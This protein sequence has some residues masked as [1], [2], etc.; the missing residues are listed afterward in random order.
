MRL[1]RLFI[2]VIL[3]LSFSSTVAAETNR[4][5]LD[6]LL[7]LQLV[8]KVDTNMV[9]LLL[10]IG[11]QYE[12]INLDSADMWYIKALDEVESINKKTRTY[13]YLKAKGIDFRAYVYK[14]KH[15]Y[16]K[17]ISFFKQA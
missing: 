7:Q 4:N 13:T 6:S 14:H 10:R 8:E 16:N 9:K 12:S 17:A 11:R 3:G 15:E 1:M 2:L 5:K